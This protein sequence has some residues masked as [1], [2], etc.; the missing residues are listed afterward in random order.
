MFRTTMGCRGNSRAAGR[1]VVLVALLSVLP[2]IAPAGAQ[3]VTD[4]ST[5]TTFTPPV[6]SK[7][8]RAIA[9]QPDGKIII[10]GR[11]TGFV[12]RLNNAAPGSG[13]NLS[14]T[15]LDDNGGGGRI[16][17]IVLGGVAVVAVLAL[18]SRRRRGRTTPTF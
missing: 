5:D 18:G 4:G 10:G 11:F 6:L 16:A 2:A 17:L 9:L 15:V 12:R 1:A 3:S 14:G 13:S 7:V 8:V